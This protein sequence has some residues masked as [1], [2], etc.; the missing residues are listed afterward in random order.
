M[1]PALDAGILPLR[2]HA[3]K[4]KPVGSG[5]HA[6]HIHKSVVDKLWRL[7]EEAYDDQASQ[8]V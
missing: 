2:R 7:P 8:Y 3:G 5:S 6:I 1:C 4:A